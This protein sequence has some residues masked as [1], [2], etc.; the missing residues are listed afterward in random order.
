MRIYAIDR[1]E[2]FTTYWHVPPPHPDSRFVV[3]RG[4]WEDRQEHGQ[5]KTFRHIREWR[6]PPLSAP[7]PQGWRPVPTWWRE[8]A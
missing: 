6:Y 2:G 3:V 5:R 1:N 4:E 7:D 8:M